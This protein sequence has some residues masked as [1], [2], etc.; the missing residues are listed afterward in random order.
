MIRKILSAAALAACA[1]SPAFALTDPGF[2]AGQNW[3]TP[4]GGLTRVQYGTPGANVAVRDDAYDMQADGYGGL[5]ANVTVGAVAAAALPGSIGVGSSFGLIETCPASIKAQDCGNRDQGYTF[6]L[7]GPQSAYGDY[8]LVR[9]M[10]ADY[11]QEFNDKVTV[12][13]YGLA[14]TLGTDRV[15]VFSENAADPYWVETGGY[16]D[17]GWAAFAVPTGTN[18]IGV[19]VQNRADVTAPGYQQGYELYNRPVVAIDYAAASPVPEADVTAMMLA[20]L[21]VLGMVARRRKA[22]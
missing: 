22:K 9:L 12:T 6:N 16:W 17:S 21:G 3:V 5:V 7:G 11:E 10:T 15:S 4:I 2:E 8:F 14:G 13:Y 1:A 18:S 20:G 19:Q